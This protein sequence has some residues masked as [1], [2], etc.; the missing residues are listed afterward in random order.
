MGTYYSIITCRNSETDIENCIYSI[1][2]QSLKPDYLLVID[3]GSSDNTS[4]ILETLKS[5]IPYLYVI[6]NPDWGYDITRVPFNYNKAIRFI[7]EN[8]LN[9]TDYHMIASDDCIYESDYAKKIITFMDK[10]RDKVFVSGNYEKSR[11]NA[12]RGSGRYVRSTY[13]KKY[14]RLYPERMGYE[15]VLLYEADM[16]GYGYCVLTDAKYEH[17][18]ALG[19]NHNFAETGP[20]MKL[21]GYHPLFAFNRFLVYFISGKPL[22][23]KGAVRMIYDYVFY[24]PYRKNFDK[25]YGKELRDFI[26]KNQVK[27]L[28]RI[29]FK[30]TFVAIK[31][32][33]IGKVGHYDLRDV[34]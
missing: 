34:K 15:T 33:L 21:L 24:K 11:Y 6:T 27:Q 14:Y 10:N 3:D 9:D 20:I 30:R 2:N 26:R 29:R 17:V 31:N 18:R 13:F 28:K 8:N 4:T 12:P 23:R 22:G 25:K 16:A 1:V 5:S 7:E 19:E 32:K